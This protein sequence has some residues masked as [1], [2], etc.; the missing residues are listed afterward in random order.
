MKKTSLVVRQPVMRHPSSPNTGTLLLYAYKRFDS[1]LFAGLREA[2][3]QGL[4]SKHGAVL[5]NLD[6]SGT[7]PTTLAQ[8]AQ[9][10][11][12]AMGELVDELERLGY[13][14]R[15][16]DAK[17]RRAKLVVPTSAGVAALDRAFTTI[18]DI[19]AAYA[20]L[21]GRTGHAALREALTRLA[22]GPSSRARPKARAEAVRGP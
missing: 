8:R 1:E 20:R 21:L 14:E 19:E 16:P 15:K 6:A 5:A 22:S 7:R 10:G 9:I 3:H 12:S 2:G 18:R 11:T 17:D 13:V 4:R